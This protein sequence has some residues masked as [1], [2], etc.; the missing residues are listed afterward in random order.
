MTMTMNNPN[1]RLRPVDMRPI[2]HEGQDFVL[3]RDPTE[4]ADETI[5][6]P[7]PLA[8]ALAF[9]D[10]SRDLP[11]ISSLLAIRYGIM[12]GPQQLGELAASLDDFL[13]LEISEGRRSPGSGP[14]CLSA[15]ALPPAIPCRSFL[16]GRSR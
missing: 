4:L 1:P 5:L 6:V 13:F 15:G 14:G 12:V 16:S 9:F 10:G 11:T 7:Q 8:T 3:L 2:Q